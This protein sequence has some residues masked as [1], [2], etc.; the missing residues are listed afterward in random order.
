MPV[1]RGAR[2]SACVAVWVPCV[3][4]TWGSGG[5]AGVWVFRA[6]LLGKDVAG[7]LDRLLLAKLVQPHRFRYA[8]ARR[9]AADTRA[10]FSLFRRYSPRPDNLFRQ[11]AR[12]H[13]PSPCPSL[14]ACAVRACA[15]MWVHECA[16]GA[17]VSP[18]HSLTHSL[19]HSLTRSLTHRPTPTHTLCV[20][21]VGGQDQ[22]GDGA[23]GPTAARTRCAPARPPPPAR[24]VT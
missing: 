12:A 21:V 2:R 23:T 1:C 13:I 20:R 14:H 16:Y 5:G 10:L 6:E 8:G 3:L 19:A 17:V 9:V 15:C 7:S 22:G 11:Y 24:L 4:L 18:W